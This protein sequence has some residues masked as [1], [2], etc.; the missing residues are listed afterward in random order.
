M[1][2]IQH[3]NKS[4]KWY[5][6]AA[7]QNHSEALFKLANF[8]KEGKYVKKNIKKALSCFNKAG[9]QGHALSYFNIGEL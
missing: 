2:D 5:V 6:S 8:Y 4:K 7:K 3:M 9:E 1:S